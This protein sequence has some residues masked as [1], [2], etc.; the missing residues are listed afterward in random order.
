MAVDTNKILAGIGP[1]SLAYFAPVDTAG[2]VAVAYTA[3]VQTI[4]I[5]GAPTGGTFTPYWNGLTPGP[6]AYNV[7]TAA[8]QTALRAAWGMSTLTVA[9][10]AGTSY[11]ITFPANRGNVSLITLVKAFTGGTTPDATVAE[12]TPGV[13]A[14]LASAV[15]PSAFFDAGWCAQDGLVENINESTS[16]VKGYGSTATLRVLLSDASRDFDLGF[17]ETNP[18]TMA[19]RNRLPVGSIVP[20]TDGSFAITTAGS[21]AQTYA[22]IFNIVDGLNFIR[23]YCPRLQVKSVKGRTFGAGKEIVNAATFTAIPDATGQA[24]YEYFQLNALAS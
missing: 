12:T 14:S 19:I 8:L 5:A 2:P 4:T 24:V 7:T 9:G 23:L 3:E 18:I 11:V 22:G 13:G 15:I 21:I 16:A 17:L 20:A 1:V 10:T 6:Q